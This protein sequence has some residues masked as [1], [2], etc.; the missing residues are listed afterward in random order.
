MWG[1]LGCRYSFYIFSFMK[2]GWLEG[3]F[4]VIYFSDEVRCQGNFRG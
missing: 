4:G 3:G 1:G 2:E